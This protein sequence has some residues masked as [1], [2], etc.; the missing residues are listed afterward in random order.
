MKA[1]KYVF[2]L[3]LISFIVTVQATEY[4]VNASIGDDTFTGTES[5]PWK[6]IQKAA[7]TLV[8]GDT[9]Y[10]MAGTYMPTQKIELI[11]SG[12]S[13]NYI[14]YLVYPG[15][16]QLVII[17]GTNITLP[18]WY[19]V[20]TIVS[21]NYIKISG[22][23]II[24]SPYAGFYVDLSTHIILENNETYQTYSSGISVWDCDLVTVDNNEVSRACWP[25]G[26]EQECI[27]IV[28]SNRVLVKNNHVFDGGSIGYGGGGEGIDIKDGSTNSIVYN[29]Y[30]HDIASVGI[31]I[32]A[33][34]TN[35]SNIQ[36]YN[37]VVNNIYGVGISLA[38]EEGGA[39]DNVTVSNNT[40]SSCEDRAMV[41]HWANKPNYL[42]KNIYVQHNTF[43][44]NGEGLDVGVH[45]LGSNIN[46]SNNIFSQNL[47]YQMQNS[48][49]DLNLSELKVRN[50][51]I[52]GVNLSWAISGTNAVIGVPEFI[53]APQNDFHLNTS[54]PAINQGTLLT[55]TTNAGTGAVIQIVDAGFF[56][57]GYGI[58]TG[59]LI[60]IEGQTQTFE[61]IA[62]DYVTNSIT[63]DQTT[64]WS[65]GAGISFTYIDNVP[66][67]GAFEFDN[68][69]AVSTERI[70]KLQIY[71]N[72]THKV[73]YVSKEYLGSQ[74]Q[75]VSL[76]GATIKKGTINTI[77]IDV[78]DVKIGVY[79]IK[80]T[81]NNLNRSLYSKL[82]IR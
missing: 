38:S 69:L 1:K 21:K 14:N 48:S 24:N 45:A 34:E 30:V 78:S 12:A 56:T 75:L 52:D 80:I 6:T 65:V 42:I 2:F 82:M 25:T 58:R 44:N 57:D 77:A 31:Y 43:Y 8:A 41:I 20:F 64:T 55:T 16:E 29:N 68:S 37:N 67:I 70:N 59:D 23:K 26:G 33:Y 4:Y 66:D 51:L 73:F 40:V 28:T 63:L 9:V 72:P 22:L 74:Y 79:L 15:D 53:D 62:I 50:N 81:K 76:A 18:N 5:Q 7:N 36:V 19:G 11:N 13:D 10:I 17:D 35:Q 32:D 39:L 71:P 27:S 49:T 60:M 46:I 54:S 47:V 61:I 3:V